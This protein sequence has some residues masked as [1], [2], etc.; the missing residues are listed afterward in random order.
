MIKEYMNKKGVSPVIATVL[1]IS[2]VVVIAL[3]V[4]F[5]IKGMQE[6][7]LVKFVGGSS[8]GV[9][10]KLVCQDVVFNAQYSGRIL[11]LENTGNPTIFRI[12]M[13]IIGSGKEDTHSLGEGSGE[14]WEYMNGLS[15]GQRTS[16]EVNVGEANKILLIPV[17][18]GSNEKG[19][20]RSYTCEDNLGK[21]IAIN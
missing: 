20:R 6:E 8:E 14:N 7:A 13:R 17:L 21:E 3:I 15:K 18:I 1:L 16:V 19:E 4:F 9:N 2:L 11:Y 12:K 5:A 10:I